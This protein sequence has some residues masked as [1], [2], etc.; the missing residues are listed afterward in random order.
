MK[1]T[2]V[3]VRC[4]CGWKGTVEDCE[5]GD[6]GQLLCPECASDVEHEEVA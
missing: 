3:V 4:Q 2:E 6:D 5:P 1:I